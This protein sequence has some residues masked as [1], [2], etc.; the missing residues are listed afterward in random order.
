M[1]RLASKQCI[2]PQYNIIVILE[3]IARYV[4][5]YFSKVYHEDVV[6]DGDTTFTYFTFCGPDEYWLPAGQMY[7]VPVKV[8]QTNVKIKWEFTTL[9]KVR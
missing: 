8:E 6:V 9:H 3:S 1:L 5:L 4:F 2:I 7:C